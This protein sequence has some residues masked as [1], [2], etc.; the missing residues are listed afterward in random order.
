VRGAVNFIRP[1]TSPE[2]SRAI[3]QQRA[4]FVLQLAHIFGKE[5]LGAADLA[6]GGRKAFGFHHLD[7]GAHARESIHRSHPSGCL[8]DPATQRDEAQ[9]ADGGV[10]Y[11]LHAE[12][13]RYQRSCFSIGNEGLRVPRKCVGGRNSACHRS[14][15]GYSFRTIV[16]WC[17]FFNLTGDFI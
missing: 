11:V 14:V 6:R 2:D 7:K 3:E 9:V 17:D 1:R 12:L 4:E 8:Q 10:E 5:R 16:R 13:E 15:S